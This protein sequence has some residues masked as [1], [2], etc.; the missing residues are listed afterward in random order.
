[1]IPVV[2][3]RSDRCCLE[4]IFGIIFNIEVPELLKICSLLGSI[5]TYCRWGYSYN[6]YLNDIKNNRISRN[7]VK[8]WT[9]R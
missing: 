7:I 8:V 4:R 9:G 1:M 5:Q 2:L 6:E 3:C